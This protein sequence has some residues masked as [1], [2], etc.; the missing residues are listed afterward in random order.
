MIPRTGPYSVQ[1]TKCKVLNE[2]WKYESMA[3]AANT[4]Y[5]N[6][7]YKHRTQKTVG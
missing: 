7:I 2:T 4:N 5:L 6:F 3:R 1:D